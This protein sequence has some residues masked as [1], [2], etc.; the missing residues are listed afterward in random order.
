MSFLTFVLAFWVASVVVL[1][2][3]WRS[4]KLVNRQRRDEPFQPPTGLRSTDEDEEEG[5]M[6][7]DDEEDEDDDYEHIPPARR[8]TGGA[9]STNPYDNSNASQSPFADPRY[10]PQ[11]QQTSYT[12]AAGRPSVDAY[13]AFSD[14]A[15]SGFGG[16]AAGAGG[17][18]AANSNSAYAA[19]SDPAQGG[20]GNNPVSNNSGRVTVPP[21]L[22]ESDFGQPIMSRTMQYADPYAAVRASVGTPVG[23]A[24][25]PPSYDNSGYQGYR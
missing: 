15:P 19:F 20:Y 23:G 2:L 8:N 17:N 21:Q 22:P 14:P 9:P 12:H 1:V 18:N 16:Y 11:Q 24:Q 3:D 5:G 7:H 4:G 25:V 6:H 13:G 10:P